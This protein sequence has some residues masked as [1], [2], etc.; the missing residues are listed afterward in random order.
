MPADHP[1][2]VAYL[3]ALA[4]RQLADGTWPTIYPG[5]EAQYTVEAVEL[6]RAYGRR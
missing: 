1:V 3:D 5:C 6:L 2:V 4:A